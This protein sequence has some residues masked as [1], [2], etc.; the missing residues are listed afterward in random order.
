M[1]MDRASLLFIYFFN[2]C[3]G[4]FSL[5]TPAAQAACG[6]TNLTWQAD[7]ASTAWNNTNNWITHTGTSIPDTATEN[8][9]VRAD[10]FQPVYPN[11]NY[12]IGCLQINSGSMTANQNRTLTI[13]GDYF[14]N[15]TLGQFINT[16]GANTFTISMAGTAAQTYENVDQVNRL[17]IANATSVTITE[18]S[19]VSDLMTINAGSGTVYIAD[20]L[21]LSSTTNVLT[22]PAS[23]TVEVQSGGSLIAMGGITVNGVLKVNSGA[24]V[25]IGNGRTLQVATG[26]ILQLAGSSGN[27]AS[28]DADAGG[29]T[30]TL[31]IVGSVNANNFSIS[32]TG[33]SG[34]NVTGT[35]QTLSNGDFHY[36]A[37][38]GH[39]VTLGA[40]ASVPAT[41]SSVG[42]FDDFNNGTARNIN[43]NAYTGSAFTVS[44]WSGGIG[45]ATYESDSGNKITWGSQAAAALQV[46][47]ATA[48]G[49]PA[50]TIGKGSADT[51]FAT[52]KFALTS[53]STSTDITAITVTLA[54]NN[55]ASDVNSIKLYKDTSAN[56]IY[57]AG[58]DTLVGTVTP[59]GSPPT[60]TFTLATGD[61]SVADPTGKCVHVLLATNSTAQTNDTLAIKIAASTDVTNSQSYSF[62]NAGGPPVT[63]G[64]STITGTA[65]AYWQGGNGAGGIGNWAQANN[66][67]PAAI[68][69][70]TTDCQVGN[71]YTVPR[72]AANQSCQNMTLP[73]SGTIDWNSTASIVSVYGA[74]TLGT[75]YTFTNATA[76]TLRFS[77]ATNQSIVAQTTFPGN[78]DINSTGGTV[79]VNN[80]WTVNGNLNL[81]SGT[82]SIA[83]G[84]TLTILGNANVNAGTL[85]INPGATL[86]IGDGRT[87]T[88]ALGATLQIVGSSSQNA[89]FTCNGTTTGCTVTVN[90]T[91]KAQYYTFDKLA[92]NGVTIGA[93]AT[94]DST[95]YLQNGTF[96]YPAVNSATLLTLNKQIPSATISDM[97]FDSSGS[98]ATGTRAINAT[99]AAAGTLTINSYSGDRTGDSFT[100][101]LPYDVVWGSATNTLKLTQEVTGPAS[102]NQ[103][104]TYFMGCYGFQQ[105]QAGS[106]SN[107]DITQ[108]R[109]TLT[110]TGS[111]S[112]IDAVRIYYDSACTCSGSGGSLLGSA[113]TYSGTPAT[114]NFTGLTGATVQTS[115]TSPPKRC[116]YVQYDVSASATSGATVGVKINSNSD[117]TNSQNYAFNGSYAPPVT[118]GSSATI[119]GTTTT[120]DGSASTVWGNAANWSGGLPTSTLNCVINSATNNPVIGAGLTGTCKSLT[121]GNGNL[122]VNATGNLEVY[123]SLTNTG[124]FTQSGTLTFRDTGAATSQTIS[125]S[126]A[127]TSMTFNKTLGG[128]ILIGNNSLTITNLLTIPAAQNFTFQVRNGDT[129]TLTNGLTINSATFQTDGGGTV[130][131]PSARTI[132]VS[133]GTFKANGT[134][135][136]YPQATSNKALY[137]NNGG[138]TTWAFTATSGTVDLTGFLFDYLDNNGLNIGGSTNIAHIDGG[139]LRSLPTAGL[140]VRPIQINTT[141]TLPT[142]NTFN[143]FGWNWAP[144]NSPPT[145]STSYYLATSTGCSSR[146]I[147]FDQWFGDFFVA[148][149][150]PD[151]QTKVSAASCTINI[152]ASASPVNLTEFK[153]TPYNNAV[154]VSWT[155]GLEWLHQG[156][157]VYRSLSPDSG[158]VQIN[159]ALLRNP[160][161]AGSI[162]GS[163]QFFDQSVVNGVTYYYSIEDVA[164]NGTRT[165]HGPLA[166]TPLSSLIAPPAPDTNSVIGH[167]GEST[168]VTPPSNPLN[169]SAPGQKLIAPGVT[170]LAKTDH[171]MRLKIDVPTYSTS[172]AEQA[173]YVRIS[174]PGYSVST[175][176]GRPELPQRVIMV[177][178]PPANS[179]IQS[180]VSHTHSI[181]NNWNIAPA[182]QWNSVNGSLI[183][184][185]VLDAAFYATNQSLP[186]AP[187]SLDPI[188]SS[189]GKYYLP[190]IVKPFSYNPVTHTVDSTTQIT[191]DLSLDGVPSWN[192]G[193]A[194]LAGNI[195]GQEGAI[196]ITL[197]K[198]GLYEITYADLMNAGVEGALAGA[199]VNKF[200]LMLQ[201]FELPLEIQSPSGF[202]SPGDSIRFFAPFFNSIENKINTLLLYVDA[203]NGIRMNSRNGSP[204]GVITS[205]ESSFTKEVTLKESHFGFFN[206]PYGEGLNHVFWGTFYSPPANPGQDSIGT[207]V[208]LPYLVQKGTVNVQ[209]LVKGASQGS[210]A[211]N[212]THHMRL[213]VNSSNASAGDATFDSSSPYLASFDVPA[214]LFVTGKNRLQLQAIG[215]L[216]PG[217]YDIIS[218]D[219]IS[220]NYPHG[221]FADSNIADVRTTQSGKSLTVSGYA[222]S[223]IFV[224]DISTPLQ[225]AK[226]SNT[227]ISSDGLG[228]YEVSFASGSG[229]RFWITH[230]SAVF[231][232]VALEYN[233]GSS[234]HT[235]SQ[236]ADVIYI[237]SADLLDAIEPLA[238]LRSQQGFRVKLVDLEDVYSEFGLGKRSAD[239][240]KEFIQYAATHWQSPS[241]SYVVLVGD[242]TYDPKNLMGFG[243]ENKF[244][245]H[246][247]PGL[248]L[249][250][251][252]DNWFVAWNSA[253]RLPNLAIGR[254]PGNTPDLVTHYVNKVLAYEAGISK[255]AGNAAARIT[256]IADIE[257]LGGEKFENKVFALNQ[258]IPSWNSSLNVQPLLRSNFTDAQFKQQI[259][260]AFNSGSIMIHYFGHGAE[261]RWASGAVFTNSD[262]DQLSNSQ[263]PIVIAMNCLNG[264]Y[265]D[266]DP[267]YQSL[268]DRLLFNE[269]GG[270]VAVWASTSLTNPASQSPYQEKIY[271]IISKNP[272]IRL[273]EA[274][275][276]AKVEAGWN[277]G[278]DEVVNSWNLLGDPMISVAI[279]APTPPQEN[280][281]D[282][283][284]IFGCGTI[285]S[286]G[287]S[288]SSGAGSAAELGLLLLVSFIATRRNKKLTS[289]PTLE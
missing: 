244:P 234:L 42:F 208:D 252:S 16:A 184:S 166:A 21:T 9:I 154:V 5:N 173:P 194:P 188:T 83:S 82:L 231:K 132:T 197:N 145:P 183:S 133:G 249:D 162:H 85:I 260:N 216:M 171:S 17:T 116:I 13:S 284:G 69:G 247:L 174:I 168:P 269:K 261:D 105:T 277:W 258:Q 38:G 131:I 281:K 137:T 167:N 26:G 89:I 230:S 228:G 229:Q 159:S 272:G 106:F 143:Y 25:I 124:T 92:L 41:W 254:I 1:K 255:P 223:N 119:I 152:A 24:S 248:F 76:G 181:L 239:V 170:L 246:L 225:T 187:V 178:I 70:N 191:V 62:S 164:N 185:W 276:R 163:Y 268:S 245:I 130:K 94:I 144:G 114:V 250:Y 101:D 285:Q 10:W 74:L 205:N 79:T 286:Q 59:T 126:S 256:A 109:L 253:D 237:G 146:T 72:L 217:D 212:G 66:W 196:K 15:L 275:R 46:T 103:G 53:A 102:V 259:K 263:L 169:P 141:G 6:A 148:M 241:L 224:Y 55:T 147:T 112:D 220:V 129:L 189:Q 96:T 165:M 37:A 117:M 219:Y 175:D 264:Y 135:D 33:T 209:A 199:D 266:S 40:A 160:V 120:W 288:G 32:R 206:E 203:N 267:N 113:G 232:P 48:S 211:K 158:F 8:A 98:G 39:A 186:H 242:G 97:N 65:V 31:N 214:N 28:L 78:L 45:G 63:G 271:E 136:G 84:Y 279:P 213:L 215:D 278:T 49:N 68:P 157:N 240:V 207:D 161:T 257:Q 138:T 18:A 155:T 262:A 88:V 75:P 221:W 52:F 99:G 142:A 128:S 202:F 35:I 67:T 289:Q 251:A 14:R 201:D 123:G 87:L 265:Y 54:G 118:L 198:A 47:D 204:T 121:I 73:A 153:A 192:Q 243:N 139:Q 151:P 179:A 226:V 193:S 222:G 91:I 77:G 172:A 233:S 274:I 80:S 57:N 81:N 61:V 283:G 195:W 29:S 44:N 104:Q 235:T 190:V 115:G 140:T 11:N 176:A 156:F 71:G 236:G 93:G 182:L 177:E 36:V 127:I 110:G 95:Y 7:A 4:V 107:T 273:G 43:A 30:Y 20:T 280:K 210:Y 180:L 150:T 3:V 2:S 19:T 100:T 64:T 86:K 50:S 287:S 270:A 90:G 60:A 22:I 58:V 23:A 218:L 238:D 149:N 125:S 227:L 111:A 122:T 200:K 34:M 27:I 51:L 134:N 56:C 282:T 108:L 12:T